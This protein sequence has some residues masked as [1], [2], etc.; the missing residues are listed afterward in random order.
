M[1]K[2]DHEFPNRFIDELLRYLSITPNEFPVASQMFESPEMDREYFDRLVDSF[3]SPHLWVRN[4][5]EW[6]LREAVWH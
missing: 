2:F 4:D 5:E 3:R 6:T 1:Q